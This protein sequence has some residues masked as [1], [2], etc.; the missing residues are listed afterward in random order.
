MFLAIV[1]AAR[2]CSLN[3][4]SCWLSNKRS[5]Q[6]YHRASPIILVIYMFPRNTDIHSRVTR[7]GHINI[8]C[9]RYKRENERGRSF[10]VSGIK[11]WNNLSVEL[12]KNPLLPSFKKSL[13]KTFL[14]KYTS[15]DHF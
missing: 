1:L 7:Y 15:A 13:K 8:V 10:T 4:L 12:R 3:N 6:C 11:T 9:P 2:F 14:D 5:K